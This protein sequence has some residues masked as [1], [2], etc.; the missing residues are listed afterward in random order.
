MVDG[1]LSLRGRNIQ[2]EAEEEYFSYRKMSSG[3]LQGSDL[4]FEITSTNN[5]N[6]KVESYSST[7]ADKGKNQTKLTV[8][9]H[10]KN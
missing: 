1:R 2:G 3:V 5:D 9:I 10:V 7:F 4:A 6:M 8:E